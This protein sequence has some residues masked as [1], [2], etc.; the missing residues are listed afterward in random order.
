M[1]DCNP[2][3]TDTGIPDR[4][5]NLRTADHGPGEIFF[6]E[7]VVWLRNAITDLALKTTVLWV[8]GFFNRSKRFG[9]CRCCPTFTYE[10]FWLHRNK[11]LNRHFKKTII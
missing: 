10:T 2:V 8:G 6:A 4:R 9:N 3:S 1:T 5:P 11:K 7:A